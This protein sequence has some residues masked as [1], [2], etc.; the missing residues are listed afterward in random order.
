MILD[1][2]GCDWLVDTWK[3]IEKDLSVLDNPS[4][5]EEIALF[6]SI[7]SKLQRIPNST[8]ELK[9]ILE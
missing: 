3:Q 4:N 2:G 6:N 7:K 9:A 8:Q 1:D 5:E